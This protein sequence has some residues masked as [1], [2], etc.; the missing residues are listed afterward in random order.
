MKLVSKIFLSLGSNLGNRLYNLSTAVQELN[1]R[2]IR[3]TACSAVYETSPVDCNDNSPPFLNAVIGIETELQPGNFIKIILDIE[4]KIGRKRS[5]KNE[6]RIID[7]D[8]ILFNNLIS[9][10]VNIILP[11]PRMGERLFVL[12]PLKEIAGEVIHPITGK[13][14]NELY[15]E[16]KKKSSEKINL[17][18]PSFSIIPLG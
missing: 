1:S 5:I 12:T 3:V 11:H 6:P 18:A 9:N 15:L 17:F 10:D 7:I 16:T 4:K 14:I 13:S 2:D 8:V